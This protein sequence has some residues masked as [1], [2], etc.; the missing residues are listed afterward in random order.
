MFVLSIFIQLAFIHFIFSEKFS[1]SAW[2]AT[3]PPGVQIISAVLSISAAGRDCARK[4]RL[5]HPQ[6]FFE[7]FTSTAEICRTTLV[8]PHF[9]HVIFFFISL[10]YSA[11]DQIRSNG[12]SHF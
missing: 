2:V 9:G 8:L 4:G 12:F 3:D 5:L 1:P 11:S 6:L 10:S 7:V